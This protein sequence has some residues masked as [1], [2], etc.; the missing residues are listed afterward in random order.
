MSHRPPRLLSGLFCLL[1]LGP[2]ARL[3]AAELEKDQAPKFLRF[4]EDN[5]GGGRL[6]TAIVSYQNPQ[7]VKVH[8]V[9]AV[10]VGEN[11]YYRDLNKTFATYDA[12][13]YEMVKPKDAGPPL[14][15]MASDNVVSIFQRLLKDVLEL[16]YQLDGIDYTP[17]NFVHAD[18]D[19]ETFARMQEERGESIFTLMLRQILNEMSNPQQMPQISLPE[20]V[21]AFTAPDRARHFKLLLGRQF[22][23]IESKV[24]GMEGPGGSVLLTERN[25]AAIRILQQTIG[26]GKKNIGLFYGAAHMKDLDQRLRTM[27]FTPV[28]TQWRTAWDMTPREG[29]VIVRTVRK[30][31]APTTQP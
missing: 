12:L 8:L 7:G 31:P 1:L 16:E 28:S 19:A 24:A 17:R 29:D 22:E 25:K 3:Q 20:L 5:E 30:K 18:L 2:M 13:L 9:G 11:K 10:H 14:P 6:E 21:V 4:V 26:A 27:G 15:G 23:D